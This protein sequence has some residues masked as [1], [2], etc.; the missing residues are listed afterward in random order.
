MVPRSEQM[1]TL[2]QLGLGDYGARAYL[3]LLDLGETEARD[4]SRLSGVPLAKMYQVLDGLQARGLCMAFHDT[5][6]RYAPVPMTRFVDRLAAEHRKAAEAVEARRADLVT[7]FPVG[8]EARASDR[9]RIQ[10]VSGR[11]NALDAEARLLGQA[12]S[13]VVAL[14]TP[15]RVHGMMAGMAEWEAAHARGVRLCLLVPDGPRW[16]EACAAFSRIAEVRVRGD[17][18]DARSAGVSLLVFDE[19]DVLVVDRT[20]DDDRA[21]RGNDVGIHVAQEG[22]VCALRDAALAL[23]ERA[24]PG[25]GRAA[26]VAVP[27]P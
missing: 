2:R 27:A 4:V 10:A 26:R 7:Q 8:G 17:A 6:K 16:E 1:E 14:C 15:G 19:T 5:P 11:Q 12:R 3:A 23:W 13:R 20:P 21:Y 24:S 22:L 9:G 18:E 25:P